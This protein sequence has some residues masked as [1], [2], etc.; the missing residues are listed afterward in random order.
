MD[1]AEQVYSLTARS[2][3]SIPSNI[4]EGAARRSRKEVIH[5]LHIA[6][7]SIAERETQ[8]MLAMRMGLISRDNPLP[9]VDDVRKMLLGLLLRSLKNN[10]ITHHPSLITSLS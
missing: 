8:L 5:F 9:H 10:P 4:V 6:S 2:A 3:V 1:L 7:G